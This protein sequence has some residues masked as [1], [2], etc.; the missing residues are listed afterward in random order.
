MAGDQIRISFR[1]LRATSGGASHVLSRTCA[2]NGR[3]ETTRKMLEALARSDEA[4]LRTM[5]AETPTFMALGA[6]LSGLDSVLDRIARQPTREMYRQAIWAAP[7]LTADGTRA[8]GHMPKDAP[9]AGV[10]LTFR[11][12]G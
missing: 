5:L 10:V 9:R 6:N 7:E 3:I 8:I 4:A 12:D 11:F 2:M 1:F